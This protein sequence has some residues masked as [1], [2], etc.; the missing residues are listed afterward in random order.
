MNNLVFVSDG[1][2]SLHV[3]YGRAIKVE[4]KGVVLKSESLR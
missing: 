3:G 2:V 4:V 1:T